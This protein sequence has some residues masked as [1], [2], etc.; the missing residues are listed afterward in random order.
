MVL[1]VFAEKLALGMQHMEEQLGN[2][3]PDLC[4]P[5]SFRED[6]KKL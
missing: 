6:F 2:N 1:T 3:T 4:S 5:K